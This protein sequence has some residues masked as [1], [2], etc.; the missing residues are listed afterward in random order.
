RCA[1]RVM[2]KGALIRGARQR[3]PVCRKFPFGSGAEVP[4]L[5]RPANIHRRRDLWSGQVRRTLINVARIWAL[6]LVIVVA[7]V[8]PG[9]ADGVV[10]HYRHKH[11]R[12]VA[13]VEYAPPYD[14]CRTGWWQ[15]LRYGHVRPLWGVGVGEVGRGDTCSVSE[16][17]NGPTSTRSEA[18]GAK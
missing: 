10:H 11:H 7:H 14:A 6:T 16:L 12:H 15:T 13:Y 17:T 2:M 18:Q 5:G 8:I 1:A 9:A 3:H 4:R